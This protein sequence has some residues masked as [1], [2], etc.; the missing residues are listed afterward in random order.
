MPSFTK[1]LF[2]VNNNT[3]KIEKIIRVAI[4]V[5]EN[6]ACIAAGAIIDLVFIV[7]NVR[8]KENT[9]HSKANIQNPPN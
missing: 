4:F 1:N 9:I 8:I 5:F 6:N 7:E 3:R 2:Q